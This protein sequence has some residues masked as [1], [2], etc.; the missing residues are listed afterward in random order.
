MGILD[1][2]MKMKG[3][4]KTD[5]EIISNL[6]SQR[7][8]PK[9]IQDALNQAQIKSAVSGSSTQGMQQS[10]MNQEDS[11]PTP[12]DENYSNQEYNAP[13][14]NQD[15]S[16]APQ[17]YPSQD[18]PQNYSPPEYSGYSQ[19]PYATQQDY[20]PQEEY[21]YAPSSS[22][23]STLMEI[24]EQVFSEK[25]KKIANTV[26]DLKEFKT[27]AQSQ[28]A[29]TQERLKRIEE[30]IDKLQISILDKIGSYGSNLSSIKKE[31]AMMQDSFSKVVDPLLDKKRK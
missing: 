30:T 14:Y 25:I 6:Q 1:T 4:G 23:T 13:Q 27:I 17:E 3:E 29:S 12:Y 16:Y 11:P 20:Y 5:Q 24:S 28:I 8:P 18:Y 21:S 7:I 9:Q 2:V 10:I 15:A 22:D 19:D 26:E 31:M